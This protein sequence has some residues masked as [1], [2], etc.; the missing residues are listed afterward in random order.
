MKRKRE[1]GRAS[2]GGGGGGGE[3]GR[4]REREMLLEMEETVWKIFDNAGAHFFLAVEFRSKAR[5]ES[6][7]LGWIKERK[8]ERRM[9]GKKALKPKR[10]WM[11]RRR[12]YK[13]CI[14][15][16]FD[17]KVDR[18]LSG[19]WVW[20][21]LSCSCSLLLLLLFVVEIFSIAEKV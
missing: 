21:S 15:G 2:E 4:E 14:K 8:K 10:A 9:E 3:K 12:R 6:L 13:F 7:L 20:S 19:S 11:R 18:L 5:F 1:R 17:N 16:I